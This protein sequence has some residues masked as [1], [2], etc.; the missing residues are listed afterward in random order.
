LLAQT[1]KLDPQGLEGFESMQKMRNRA[2]ES[3]EF[4]NRERIKAAPM[5]IG[6]QTVE[7]RAPFLRTRDS[8]IDI[9]A[10]RLPSPTRH[11]LAQFA[12]LDLGVLPFS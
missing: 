1:H 4:P 2:G 7:L 5:S 3:I 10:N 8:H 11:V 6:D 9:L 12:E